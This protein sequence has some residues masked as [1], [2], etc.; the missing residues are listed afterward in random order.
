LLHIND[1]EII[2]VYNQFI[3]I[4]TGPCTPG[5]YCM[6]RKVKVRYELMEKWVVF[7]DVFDDVMFLTMFR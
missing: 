1:S 7:D 6:R 2:K 3:T 5:S 4:V